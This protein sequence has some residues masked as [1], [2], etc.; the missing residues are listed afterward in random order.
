MT[1]LCLG[2]RLAYPRYVSTKEHS[3]S[4][5]DGAVDYEPRGGCIRN[6]NTFCSDEIPNAI[7][8]SPMPDDD[9]SIYAAPMDDHAVHHLYV[10]KAYN[11]SVFMGNLRKDIK[12]SVAKQF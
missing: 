1:P 7:D 8:D 11:H 6:D 9:G 5:S 10:V 4:R 2:D 3:E 12:S